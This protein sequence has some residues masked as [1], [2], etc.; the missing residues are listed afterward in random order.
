[1]TSEDLQYREPLEAYGAY[2]AAL[3]AL[4][5]EL[6]RAPSADL[7]QRVAEALDGQAADE[8]RRLVPLSDL[9]A[10]GIFFTG[11]RLAQRAVRD[12]LPTLE[13]ASTILDPACGA[14]DLLIACAR[15]LAT[16]GNAGAVQSWGSRLLGRDLHPILVEV[17]RRRLHLASWELG[18]QS[19][20]WS[21]APDDAFP[22]IINGCG[23]SDPQAVGSASHVVMNPP[24]AAVTAPDD[25][26]WASGK[27]NAS[28]LFLETVLRQ[29]KPGTRIVAILPDV[30]RSGSRYG[31]WRQLVT[32]RCQIDRLEIVGR[33]DR[34]ADVDV[35]ILQ[36]QA[37]KPSAKRLGLAWSP[38]ADSTR[39][40]VGDRFEIRIGPVVDYRD[41]HRG[42]WA[43]FIHSR[44]L[45]PWG[46]VRE[47][48]KR[49]RFSGR[50]LKPP[51]VAIRRTSRPGDRHR[52]VGT[53]ILGSR[54]V[55]V[56]NHVIALLPRD[57]TRRTCHE[58]LEAL[59]E[60]RTTRW[61]D[62]RIRCRHLT[63]TAL[64][65][66]PWWSGGP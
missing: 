38:E 51:F 2:A 44:D 30:L 11:S 5:G 4:V 62:R 29:A 35:F 32:D 54:G 46:T 23:L 60:E 17:A 28:A 49:R 6:T 57:G 1:M 34:W 43:P 65:E 61:L 14:G 18:S 66:L 16:R 47:I 45:P 8:L 39:R 36:L 63:V 31:K 22:E 12:L 9:R 53:L 37:G 13:P 41:P 58:L 25:C 40:Q 64:R 15:G 59:R 20:T 24:F 27:V 50:L 3:D 56:E 26:S 7:R 48:P 55:A 19:L 10:D 33:F 52:A 21:T 42:P